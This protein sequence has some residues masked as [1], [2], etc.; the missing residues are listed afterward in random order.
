MV[1]AGGGG[2]GA[3]GTSGPGGTGGSAEVGGN[4]GDN[5]DVGAGAGGGPGTATA[6]GGGGSSFVTAAALNFN[7]TLTSNPAFVTI[8]PIAPGSVTLLESP[9]PGILGQPVT[10]IANVTG[11]TGSGTPTGTV[12]FTDD[13]PGPVVIASADLSNGFAKTTYTWSLPAQAGAHRIAAHYSGDQT[14]ASADSPETL[15]A[16]DVAPSIA[17]GGQPTD[18]TTLYGETASFSVSA[19]GVPSPSIQ[20]QVSRDG[21][22]PYNA[23]AGATSGTYQFNPHVSD[24]GQHF[25]AYLTNAVGNA[26]SAAAKLTVNPA[27]LEVQATTTSM[28]KGGALPTI[29]GTFPGGSVGFVNGDTASSLGGTLTCN[30]TP[31]VSTSLGVGQYPINCSGL[32]SSD[33]TLVYVAG[34][35]TVTAA[36][37]TITFTT[38]APSG[39]VVGTAAYTPAATGG[40]SGNG[41]V[42]S[43][44]AASTNSACSL[45]SGAFHFEHTGNCVIDANQAG[46]ADYL[47]APQAQQ[48]ITVD[49]APQT[50]TFT[51]P[52]TGT[53]GTFTSLSATGGASG[54]A[55]VFSIDASSGTGV[56]NVSGLNG[57][58]LTFAAVGS[59]AIDANQTGSADYEAAPQVQQTLTVT[60]ATPT[61][62]SSQM[63]TT[64]TVGDTTFTDMATVSGGVHPSGAVTFTLYG[65]FTA[66]VTP[67]CTGKPVFTGN[68]S[69]LSNGISSTTG[70]SVAQPGTYYWVASIAADSDNAA[71]SSGCAAEPIT[72][73]KAPTVVATALSASSVVIGTAVTDS[74]T[75][76]GTFGTPTGSV[77]YTAY[78]GTICTGTPV[79]SSA[80]T[81]TSTGTMPAS[82]AFTPTTAG[83]Y[84]WQASYSGDADNAPAT[85]ACGSETLTVTERPT[86]L[87]YNGPTRGDYNDAVTPS[88]TLTDTSVNPPAGVGGVSVNFTLGT[89]VCSGT[90]DTSGKATCSP[91]T[92][93]QAPGSVNSV[94][95]SFAGNGTYLPSSTTPAPQFT[96]NKEETALS[97][98]STNVLPSNGV[99]VSA[100]LLED[101]ST[102]PNPNGQTVTFTATPSG[103]GSPASGTGTIDATG[104]AKATLPLPVGSYAVTASFA[105]DNDYLGSTA[106]AQTAYVYAFPAGGAFVVGDGNASV[107]TA[108]NFWG[109]KWAKNNTLSGGAAPNAFK[110]FAERP[111]STPPACGSSYTADM[112]GSSGPPAGPLPAYMGVLVSSS[113]SKSGSTISGN[114]VHI[115]VV[116]N[117]SGYAP[118]PRGAGT[119]TIMATVC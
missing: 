85:N 107:G 60:A 31:P 30:S 56:C 45:S 21:G 33:Y 99:S 8:T 22:S 32:S 38:T 53:V 76:T 51:G 118:D 13:S 115:V 42:F 52:G 92:L 82:G 23:I 65:P 64:G 104:T 57:A 79:F 68:G 108:I 78:S 27:Q 44:D 73:S 114:I 74:A 102:V 113:I 72:V 105:G 40:A 26:T 20:W 2:G 94:D 24:S 25:R 96:I 89:Q 1:A 109:S 69:P 119:G 18:Q 55:V 46:N 97:I 4:P 75:L 87:I 67:S 101:G 6:A 111:S 15:I 91:M 62:T 19:L 80:Q 3:D 116:D 106:T 49:Q 47:A 17:S 29:T 84:S 39:V 10:L 7:I 100:K 5:N 61:V 117:I 34:T 37:Q 83:T 93:S 95:V 77:T 103:G 90:T 58:T 35:L 86:A 63:P 11:A 70:T 28:V 43:I 98:T 71:A 14:H 88:A 50:I 110:G 112:G 48:T 66:S 41:V 9:N 54:N 81:L 12:S 16:I 36:P 59:C